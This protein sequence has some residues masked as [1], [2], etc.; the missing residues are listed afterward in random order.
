MA[1][2]INTI[3]MSLTLSSLSVCLTSMDFGLF[4]MNPKIDTTCF[5]NTEWK[6]AIPAVLADVPDVTAGFNLDPAE[7]PTLLAEKGVNQSIS[8]TFSDATT[9]TL[10]FWGYL[11]SVTISAGEVDGL[12]TGSITIVATNVNGSDTETGPTFA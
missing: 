8:I 7:V 3:G 6:T 1:E 12:V 2:Y 5:G 9:S 10:T 11:S 4:E